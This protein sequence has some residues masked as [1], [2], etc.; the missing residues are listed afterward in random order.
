MTFV[1]SRTIPYLHLPCKKIVAQ[2]AT[3]CYPSCMPRKD[4]EAIDGRTGRTMRSRQALCDAFLALVLEGNLRPA[5]DE[6]AEKA[7]LSRRSL[8]HHFKDLADLYDAAYELG[9]QRAA[10]LLKEI[11]PSASAGE[12]VAM[13]VETRCTFLEVTLPF[14][15]ELTARALVGPAQKQARQSALRRMNQWNHDIE[16]IF[17]GD[18]NHLPAKERREVLQAIGVAISSPTWG[19]LRTSVGMSARAARSSVNRTV[20]GILSDAG[21][22]MSEAP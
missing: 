14:H 13:L 6:I 22:D 9:M 10:P 12:R 16:T 20:R 4:P 11:P 19:Y 15:W 17:A 2:L 8:F 7:G 3:R 18:L 5:A 21:V 1:T